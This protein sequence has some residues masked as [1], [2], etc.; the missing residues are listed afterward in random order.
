M[1]TMFTDNSVKITL[2]PLNA[3]GWQQQPSQGVARLSFGHPE[4]LAPLPK[5]GGNP[6]PMVADCRGTE[7][8]KKNQL[9][10]AKNMDDKRKVKA[11]GRPKAS[12]LRKLTKSVTVKFSKPDYERLLRRSRQ[13]N[14]TLAEYIRDS[15][16]EA[17][18]VA[19]HSMEEATTMR[20]LVGMANNLNQLTKLSHQMGFYRTKNVI[21]DLLEKLKSIMNDYKATERRSR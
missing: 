21:M 19:K 7:S 13:A 2:Q 12:S 4:N 16:F 9:S 1:N 6:L 15:A 8:K 11:R 3:D 17:Q 18:V 5:S 10:R 14:R 20:N